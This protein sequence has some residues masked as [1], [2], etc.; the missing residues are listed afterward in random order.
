MGK[1]SSCSPLFPP[2]V[3]A[4]R[5]LRSPGRSDHGPANQS[6]RTRKSSASLRGLVQSVAES[7]SEPGSPSSAVSVV[8][9]FRRLRS[10]P[11]A[12]DNDVRSEI[13]VVGAFRR[14]ALRAR[15]GGCRGCRSCSPYWS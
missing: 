12:I 11:I 3:P 15:V 5:S 4:L 14:V 8:G 2:L 13:S 6:V 1:P 7:D 9:A 10:G